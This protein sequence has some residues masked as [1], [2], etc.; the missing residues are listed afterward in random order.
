MPGPQSPQG[1]VLLQ[2]SDG[3]VSIARQSDRVAT[4]SAGGASMTFWIICIV[5]GIGIGV[6]AYVIVSA[7]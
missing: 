6:V 2:P 1:T 5:C 7:L 4:Q 3:V